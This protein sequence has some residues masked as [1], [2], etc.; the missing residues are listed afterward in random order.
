MYLHTHLDSS[1]TW[2]LRC[3][4]F[5]FSIVCFATRWGRGRT[6]ATNVWLS[7]SGIKGSITFRKANIDAVHFVWTVLQDAIDHVIT[8]YINHRWNQALLFWYLLIKSNDP[9]ISLIVCRTN[10]TYY[11]IGREVI[12]DSCLSHWMATHRRNDQIGTAVRISQQTRIRYRPMKDDSFTI[13]SVITFWHHFIDVRFICEREH[14]VPSVFACKSTRHLVVVRLFKWRSIL[15]TN[16]VCTYSLERY[17][18]QPDTWLDTV[19][20]YRKLFW[21]LVLEWGVFVDDRRVRSGTR[22]T[23]EW[24]RTGQL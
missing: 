5:C 3:G 18:G 12:L 9:R 19:W 16:R 8:E 6:S 20:L 17:I 4:G 2:F 14:R 21:D 11:T 10:L 22:S 13:D 24:M 7:S 15:S 1:R 23:R